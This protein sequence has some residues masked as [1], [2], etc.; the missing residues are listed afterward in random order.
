MFPALADLARDILTIP[1]TRARV[2][3]LF[4][5]TRDVCHYRRGSLK[6]STI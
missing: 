1:A 6:P 2:E 4:N 3:R 5:S